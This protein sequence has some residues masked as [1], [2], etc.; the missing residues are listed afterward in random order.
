ME[1]LKGTNTDEKTELTTSQGQSLHETNQYMEVGRQATSTQVSLLNNGG[2]R[3]DDTTT[4]AQGL[5]GRTLRE[6]QSPHR[7]E[8]TKA[9]IFTGFLTRQVTEAG[10]NRS[11][12]RRREDWN[13]E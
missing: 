13:L 9:E 2:H 1:G 10:N 11:G 12:K 8:A 4:Q 7:Q 5:Q 6:E 3:D